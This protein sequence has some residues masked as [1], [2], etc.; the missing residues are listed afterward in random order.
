MKGVI[1]A[2]GSGTRLRPITYE[3]P[4]PLI[5]VKK[6][7]ILNHIINFFHKYDVNDISVI[8]SAIHENDFQKWLKYWQPKKNNTNTELFV[9]EKPLGTFGCFPRLKH[10]LNNGPIIVSNG[11]HLIDFDLK[12]L[13]NFHSMKKPEATMALLEVHNPQEYGVPV[14]EGDKI[15][16]FE[17]HP[18]NPVSNFISAGVY[19]LELSILNYHPKDQEYV[20]IENDI[21]PKVAKNGTLLGLKLSDCRLY[22]CGTLER[23]EKAIKE[24]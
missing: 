1:L 12:N 20:M 3:I 2:G 8:I 5:T 19:V 9:E 4:K 24:W 14:L 11:D 6:E 7:P 15:I 21:F 18:E 13:I 10:W 17:Y 23:W 22:D 16:D